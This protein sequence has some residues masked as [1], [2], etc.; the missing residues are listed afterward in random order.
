MNRKIRTA[1]TKAYDANVQELTHT[2]MK[3]NK[4]EIFPDNTKIRMNMWFHFPDRRKRD[5]HNT[6]K[7]PMDAMQDILYADD[8]WVLPNIVDFDIDREN[9][10]LDLEFYIIERNDE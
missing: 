6:F 5:T 1:K 10:R 7:I 8:Y 3:Q 9:P 2:A 4:F